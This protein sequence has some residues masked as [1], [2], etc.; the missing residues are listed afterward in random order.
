M[1]LD[2]KHQNTDMKGKHMKEQLAK[3]F[4]REKE[5]LKKAKD[6]MLD[7]DDMLEKRAEQIQG[8]I[9]RRLNQDKNLE[10]KKRK[11]F[12]KSQERQN[13]VSQRRIELLAEKSNNNRQMQAMASTRGLKENSQ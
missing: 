3:K 12:Q 11:E 1:V 4:K 6:D 13:L 2:R 9:D 8:N 5:M 7:R 10:T